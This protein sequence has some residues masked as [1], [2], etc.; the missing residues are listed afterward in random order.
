MLKKLRDA[1]LKSNVQA[2][3][4]GWRKFDASCDGDLTMVGCPTLEQKLEHGNMVQ[5]VDHTITWGL[6]LG[7]RF[8]GATFP[9]H[10]HMSPIRSAS[11]GKKHRED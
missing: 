10:S 4:A 9:D 7:S 6:G 11:W 5:I 2:M 1:A 8:R 3:K